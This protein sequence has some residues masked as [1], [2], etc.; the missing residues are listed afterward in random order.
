MNQ[1]ETDTISA[2]TDRKFH[3][4]DDSCLYIEGVPGYLGRSYDNSVLWDV[5][6][7]VE[8]PNEVEVVASDLSLSDAVVRILA[9]VVA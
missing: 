4:E 1:N 3:I 9:A 2:L 6:L 7:P 8:G 5:V